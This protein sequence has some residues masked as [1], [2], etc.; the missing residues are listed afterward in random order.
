MSSTAPDI[1][2]QIRQAAAEG[3]VDIIKTALETSRSRGIDINKAGPTTG[4]TALHQAVINNQYDVVAYLVTRP[5][6][7]ALS[8]KLGKTPHVYAFENNHRSILRLLVKR[9]PDVVCEVST[10]GVASDDL[11]Y[12]KGSSFMSELQTVLQQKDV[13]TEQIMLLSRAFSPTVEYMG[14]SFLHYVGLYTNN[15]EAISQLLQAGYDPNQSIRGVQLLG[16]SNTPLH[17]YLANESVDEACT[18]VKLVQSMGKT[19]DFT[20]QDDEGKTPLLLAAKIRRPACVKELLRLGAESSLLI[21][22]NEGR[23][24]LHVMCILGDREGIKLLQEHGAFDALMSTTDASGRTP[25]QMLDMTAMET[26]A[27]IESISIEPDRDLNAPSN[28]AHHG[29]FAPAGVSFLDASL[30]G[31]AAIREELALLSSRTLTA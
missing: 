11:A 1:H 30:A 13:S 31:R 16:Y 28:A 10:E 17:S 15:F 22:D 12:T 2:L 6:L 5:E 4:K 27:F 25:L 26:R 9:F 18:Y 24:I 20:K 7:Q 8:D 23:T 21:P 3:R 14:Y 29:S 19:I